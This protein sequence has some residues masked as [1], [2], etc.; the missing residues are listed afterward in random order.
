MKTKTVILL[1]L[2]LFFSIG[3][4]S[5]NKPSG[6]ESVLSLYTTPEVKQISG[7]WVEKY[8]LEHSGFQMN[9]VTA[10]PGEI[11]ALISG[12]GLAIVTDDQKAQAGGMNNWSIV[13]G[14]DIIVPV[15][16]GANPMMAAIRAK[17][18]SP[19]NLAMT[20]A[21][22]ASATWGVAL[23]SD[24]KAPLTL[25][26]AD[27]DA[28]KAAVAGFLNKMT[29]DGKSVCFVTTD[30][31]IAVLQKDPM[32]IGFCRLNSIVDAQGQNLAGDLRL[33]PI[34]R[35]GN[36]NLDLMEKIYDNPQDLV[37][38][39]WI[40]KYPKALCREIFAVA[41]TQPS[42]SNQVA[43]LTWV[44]GNGQSLLSSSGYSELVGNE[45]Q[46]QL[47]KLKMAPVMPFAS[48]KAYSWLD[49]ILIIIAGVIVVTLLVNLVLHKAYRE[50]TTIRHEAEPSATPLEVQKVTIPAGLYF[51]KSHT[52]LFREKDG[53]VRV[54]I[55]DFMQH[56]MGPV[57]RIEMK[58][59]GDAVRK[60]DVLVTI[61][62]RGKQLNIYAPVTGIIASR[63]SALINNSSLINTS[64]YADGWVY[65]IEP[66]N[67]MREIQFLNMAE[68]YRGW[69]ENEFS[70]LKDFLAMTFK[71][72]NLEYS[73]VV[74]QDGGS[75]KDHV[76]ADLGPEVWDDFQTNFIDKNR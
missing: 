29:L 18:I 11:P 51:D 47:N 22:P 26:I 10:L 23:N 45:I 38:G 9:V 67:W 28:V 42:E 60:G 20:I 5:E 61:I 44:L 70:R 71:T 72:N 32:A 1:S 7:K 56:I 33:M 2:M 21:D 58:N 59:P 66:D 50:I 34:D 57:T 4:K 24:S 73:H 30:R 27:D 14:R 39:V 63:N 48:N 13:L 68:K 46:S 69:L 41:S 76:L 37:R 62:Q 40:G 3:L 49:W 64:P 43:F 53:S 8:N 17:G 54:G 55:D 35:N 75:L 74:L 25:Y 12:R 52:W 15:I 65:T 36:G 6:T 19:D 31:L 16:S